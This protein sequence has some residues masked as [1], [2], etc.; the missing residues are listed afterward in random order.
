MSSSYTGNN[1]KIAKSKKISIHR[2]AEPYR[3]GTSLQT[4]DTGE[5]EDEQATRLI[6][7]TG[8]PGVE[9]A[10][11]L[12]RT[13]PNGIGTN[14]GPLSGLISSQKEEHIAEPRRGNTIEFNEG[15][16]AAPHTSE[17][18]PPLQSHDVGEQ[19]RV[20]ADAEV[21]ERD[22]SET[23][24]HAEQDHTSSP[25]E[26][27]I[28]NFP[29]FNGVYVQEGDEMWSDRPVFRAE[30]NLIYWN[31]D[32]NMWW[33][34]RDPETKDAFAFIQEMV[35]SREASPFLRE[36][37]RENSSDRDSSEALQ[38]YLVSGEAESNKAVQKLKQVFH[39]GL[40]VEEFFDRGALEQAEK[41]GGE[42]LRIFFVP[43]NVGGGA[44]TDASVLSL[45]FEDEGAQ[46]L[47]KVFSEQLANLCSIDFA[48]G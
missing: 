47:A 43:Y 3:S 29:C 28:R 16:E 2:P 6:V 13:I 9:Q 7:S 48:E 14:S 26:V 45:D 21:V 37:L 17:E 4:L 42:S 41:G 11:S 10:H 24:D 40:L 15:G 31:V 25:P 8:T 36:A 19:S 22:E 20:P 34:G 1:K 39:A 23:G 35:A 33:V 44:G 38:Q 32:Y 30:D 46:P 5:D 12:D 27:T 18:P